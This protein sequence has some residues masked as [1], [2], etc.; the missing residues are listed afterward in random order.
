MSQTIE[1]KLLD[2]EAIID[3]AIRQYIP[4][5]ATPPTDRKEFYDRGLYYLE[6]E[7][8]FIEEINTAVDNIYA[9]FAPQT[10][11]N[12]DEY[13]ALIKAVIYKKIKIAPRGANNNINEEFST[14]LDSL[15]A[16]ANYD[17]AYSK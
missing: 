3:T 7:A 10:S 12:E 4:E 5:L 11:A 14:P 2:K 15:T 9:D 13:K 1:E 8:S 16:E 17:K 6:N